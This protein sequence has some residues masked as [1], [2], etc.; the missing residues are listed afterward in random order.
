MIKLFFGYS[1]MQFDSAEGTSSKPDAWETNYDLIEKAYK[2]AGLEIVYWDLSADGGQ[3]IRETE[4]S[5]KK[6]VAIAMNGF[7][8]AMLNVFMSRLMN[9]RKLVKTVVS[10]NP[11]STPLML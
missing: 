4:D 7:S 9:G 11:F 6:G 1:D 5:R 8:P 3:R 2:K 10:K